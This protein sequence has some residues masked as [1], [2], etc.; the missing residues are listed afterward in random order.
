M[1]TLETATIA[2]GRLAVTYSKTED[3]E[4]LSFRIDGWEDA[5]QWVRKVLV[6]D[7]REFIWSCWNSDTNTCHFVRLNWWGMTAPIATVRKY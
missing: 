5:S 4:F 2:D 3:R 7:G 6:Y 1:T